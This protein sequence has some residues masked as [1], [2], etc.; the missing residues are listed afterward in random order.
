MHI[1]Q[2]VRALTGF[3]CTLLFA[4]DFCMARSADE[5][6]SDER[7]NGRAE[8][9]RALGDGRKTQGNDGRLA[10]VL[11]SR[12]SRVLRMEYGLTE[13]GVFSRGDGDF[14]EPRRALSNC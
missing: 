4:A 9:L 13:R 6:C 12:T 1:R 7:N 14:C 8:R 5:A 2:K 3:G 11:V 10:E